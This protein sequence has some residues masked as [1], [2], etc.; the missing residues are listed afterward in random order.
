MSVWCDLSFVRLAGIAKMSEARQHM[1]RHDMDEH[2]HTKKLRN[3]SPTKWEVLASAER[4]FL[5]SLLVN[6]IIPILKL[7]MSE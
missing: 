7:K 2:Y 5:R 3:E 4:P 1:P 6:L